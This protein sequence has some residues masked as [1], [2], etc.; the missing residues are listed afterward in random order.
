RNVA[1]GSVSSVASSA[2]GN[3]TIA[4]LPASMYQLTITSPGFKK[5]V[6]AGLVVGVA[7]TL[8]V[9][10]TLEVGSAAESVTVTESTPL[11]K[12]EGGD[13]SHNVSTESMD[14]LPILTLQVA[15][16]I[17]TAN[18]LGNIRNPLAAV[19]LLP[20]SRMTTDSVMRING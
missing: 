12:T 20:G 6:R 15:A 19:G 8:R 9:D 18:S 3:Y 4:Q 13:I 5:F 7:A 17:G 16:G 14:N 11:L 10:A 1:T 2:T